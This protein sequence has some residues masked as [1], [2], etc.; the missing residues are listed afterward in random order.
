[1]KTS[2]KQFFKLALFYFGGDQPVVTWKECIRYCAGAFIGLLVV[3]VMA[4]YLG[5]I[6]GIGE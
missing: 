4:K 6:S 3:I 1:M 2:P 5:E